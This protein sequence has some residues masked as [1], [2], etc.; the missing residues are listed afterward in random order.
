MKRIFALLLAIVM[1]FS[2]A[3]CNKNP[4]DPQKTPSN[5]ENNDVQLDQYS[6]GL[7]ENGFY[8]DYD[9]YAVDAVNLHELEVNVDDVL[10]YIASGG[11]ETEVKP[12]DI[13]AYVYEY[14]N[15]VL[16]S[17][18]L[19]ARETVEDMYYVN[20]TLEFS[21]DGKV[22][23]DMGHTEPQMYQ[24]NST[25]DE[26][27][28]SLLG[29]KVNDEYEV[30]YVFPAEDTTYGGKTA[31][32]KI[33]ITEINDNDPLSAGAIEKNAEALKEYF[34]NADTK[35]NFL[36]EIR[37]LIAYTH[38]LDYFTY[39]FQ[40]YEGIEA[41]KELVDHELY[42]FNC[43][44]KSFGY[45]MTDYIEASKITEEEIVDY[46]E[47]LVVENLLLM[48][49]YKQSG[50]TD[51]TEDELK[52]MYSNDYDYTVSMLGIP[53]M[54][55]DIMREI[56]LN[57]AAIE[58][59]LMFNGEKYTPDDKYFE[60]VQIDGEQSN[61]ESTETTE[62]TVDTAESTED[63]TQPTEGIQNQ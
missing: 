36:N 26:I 12:E 11:E 21:I 13:D 45:T 59:N 48:S 49:I 63:A 8:I 9:K 43:R 28:K 3:A 23:E 54:K 17:L 42:R 18:G 37:P 57:H 15:N 25:G 22:M 44:L 30:T 61:T 4:D 27:I 5:L 56:A 6:I 7:D 10:K 55:L 34:N 58:A 50:E 60:K 39:Y 46:C 20:C 29:H 2:L 52:K 14:A 47:M 19:A 51:I 32:V 35:E 38:L 40:T 24:A 16:V 1:V 31:T 62:P 33:K 41:P 53:Y